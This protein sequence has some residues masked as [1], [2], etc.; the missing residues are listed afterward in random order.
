V[1]AIT[2]AF[3]EAAYQQLL[4]RLENHFSLRTEVLAPA[5][6]VVSEALYEQL[7]DRLEDHLENLLNQKLTLHLTRMK[8]QIAEQVMEEM[9]QDTSS[10]PL[11]QA[12]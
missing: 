6:P 1:T 7:V 10:I 12:L 11:I 8:A 3:D 2:T 4:T 5:I 9:R